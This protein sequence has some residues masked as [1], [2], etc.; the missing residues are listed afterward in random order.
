MV[1][2]HVVLVVD[3]RIAY[4]IFLENLM[5]INQFECSDLDG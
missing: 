4:G 5:A 1:G 3:K 2:G